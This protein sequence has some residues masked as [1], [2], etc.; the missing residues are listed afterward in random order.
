VRLRSA[1]RACAGA[2]RQGSEMF[3]LLV[4]ACPSVRVRHTASLPEVDWISRHLIFQQLTNAV[5]RV[6][7]L[8]LSAPATHLVRHVEVGQVGQ[9]PCISPPQL[10]TTTLACRTEYICI[11]NAQYA[12]LDRSFMHPTVGHGAARSPK[13][14]SYIHGAESSSTSGVPPRHLTDPLGGPQV[15]SLK[16]PHVCQSDVSVH[17]MN[18]H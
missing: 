16:Q 15:V 13:S 7:N 18:V 11:N 3:A 10:L 12:R 1:D 9:A 2:C 5:M 17:Q 6:A 8:E 14:R 4:C